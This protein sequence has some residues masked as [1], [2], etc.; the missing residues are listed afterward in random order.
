MMGY[1]IDMNNETEQGRR[2]LQRKM[3]GNS[4]STEELTA[5]DA[6]RHEFAATWE[7]PDGWVSR[8]TCGKQ[9]EHRHTSSQARDSLMQH[10][11]EARA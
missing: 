6:R 2:E 9:G 7:T 10:I 4:R 11:A 8:C 1:C 3:L 5:R